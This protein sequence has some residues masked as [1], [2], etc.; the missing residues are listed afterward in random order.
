VGGVD[1]D[2]DDD[3]DDDDVDDDKSDIILSPGAR[4]VTSS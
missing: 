4:I 1:D 3:D 2:C